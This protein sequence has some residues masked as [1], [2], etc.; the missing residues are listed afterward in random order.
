M[1]ARAPVDG[2]DEE[3]DDGAFRT[4][5]DPEQSELEIPSFSPMSQRTPCVEAVGDS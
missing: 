1:K 5:D 3:R 4:I 2:C